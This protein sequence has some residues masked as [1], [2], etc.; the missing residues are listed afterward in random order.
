MWTKKN[1]LNL[2]GYLTLN[3]NVNL[4]FEINTKFCLIW[5]IEFY[6]RTNGGE[7]MTSQNNVAS[8]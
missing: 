6:I 8:S 5:Y 7:P 1:P 4:V 3:V 2:S